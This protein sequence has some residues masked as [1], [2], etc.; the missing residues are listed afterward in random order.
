S[1]VDRALLRG[2]LCGRS[3]VGQHAVERAR[4][5]IEVQRLDEQPRVTQLS[6]VGTAEE[7]PQLPLDV[8]APPGRLLLEGSEWTEIPVGVEHLFHACGAECS[9]QLVLEIGDADVETESL[10][11]RPRE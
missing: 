4:N 9:D 11:V 6:P 10:H 7:A 5:A 3:D 8:A 1:A 2:G